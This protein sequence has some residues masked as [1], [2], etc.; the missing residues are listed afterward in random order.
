MSFLFVPA[1]AVV[2]RR[3]PHRRGLALGIVVGGSALGGVIWPIM[4]NQLLNHNGVSFGW[5]MRVVAFTMIPL[6]A[7]TCLTVVDAPND[8]LA[9]RRSQGTQDETKDAV[10]ENRPHNE[11]AGPKTAGASIARGT[12]GGAE[13]RAVAVKPEAPARSSKTDL[14]ILKSHT[15]ILLSIGLF[16]TY[17]GL[18]TPLF[19]ISRYAISQGVSESTSFYL[20]A[21]LNACSFFG[22][23]IPAY[24]ADYYGHY[25]I[26]AIC[27]LLAAIIGFCL[28]A[29]TNLAGLIVWTLAYGFASGTVIALQNACAGKI[30]PRQSQGAAVGFV[31]AII[32]IP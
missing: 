3:L 15:Y 27:I 30:A 1:V 16:F 5:S 10:V 24:L 25:N 20:L 8:R 21:A 11:A 2:S 12:E 19:Y 14:S 7:V 13:V 31:T 22:R 23:V 6:L 17:L 4:L 29:T 32:S 18:F 28:T 26:Q 9:V